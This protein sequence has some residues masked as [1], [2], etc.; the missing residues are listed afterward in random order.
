[1]LTVSSVK[2]WA[3]YFAMAL[4]CGIFA[5]YVPETFGAPAMSFASAMAEAK[6]LA[7]TDAGFRYKLKV[8]SELQQPLTK[9]AI[10]CT[11]SSSQQTFALVLVFAGDGRIGQVLHTPK[12]PV[13]ACVAERIK[14]IRVSGPPQSGWL[15]NLAMN[16]APGKWW[17]NVTMHPIPTDPPKAQIAKDSAV[18]D[19]RYREERPVRARKLSRRG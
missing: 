12:H 17:I 7:R 2:H 3:R 13:A 9:A 18:I 1:M 8:A 5:F 11:H 10:G 14:G 4:Y 15:L 6:R 16:S 19:R